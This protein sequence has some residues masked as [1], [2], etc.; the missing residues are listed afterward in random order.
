MLGGGV[1]ATTARSRIR[2]V[3]VLTILMCLS[4][5]GLGLLFRLGLYASLPVAPGEPYGEA[6]VLELVHYEALVVFSALAGLQGLLLLLLGRL[7]LRRLGALMCVFALT[8][9]FAYRPIHGWV[10][11]MASR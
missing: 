11:A 9:P 5:A 8:L 3:A 7:Q 10:A 4:W 2:V 1:M 6:D